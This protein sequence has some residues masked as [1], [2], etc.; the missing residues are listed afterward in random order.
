M[1]VVRDKPQA[2]WLP[3]RHR[4]ALARLV[5]YAM[6]RFAPPKPM[7][8]DHL[9]LSIDRDQS[10]AENY[11]AAAWY[12]ATVLCFTAALL[13]LA[14]P[15]ALI[16]AFPLSLIVVQIPI[17]AAGLPFGN[18]RLT[19]IVY[20]TCGAAA[21]LYFASRPT[22][23]RFPAYIYLGVLSLNA[24]AFVIMWLLRHQVRAAEDRCVA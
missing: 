24:V 4:F 1:N 2:K 21:S 23:I 18:C 19:S 17:Y 6:L 11:A 5:A 3:S 14:T 10:A 20:A 22:W 12:F 16:A 13:P 7:D 8:V 9:I 15:W